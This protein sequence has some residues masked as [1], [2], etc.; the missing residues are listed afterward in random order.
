MDRR[1]SQI[2]SKA[3]DEIALKA[4]E[5][6]YKRMGALA[7]VQVESKNMDIRIAVR[8]DEARSFLESMKRK[9]IQ[10]EEPET[11]GMTSKANAQEPEPC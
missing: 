11:D 9:S 7:P 2:I 8:G 4:I 3:D 5:L 6:G 10:A 1:L